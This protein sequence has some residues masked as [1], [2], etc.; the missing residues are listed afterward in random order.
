MSTKRLAQFT[1]GLRYADLSPQ[2]VTKTKQCI[3]DWLGV[4]I[5]GSQEKP[6]KIIREL[7]LNGGGKGEASVL[8]GQGARTT[9]LQAAFC[10]GAASH[11]LDFDDLHNPSIIHLATVVVPPVFA[12]AEAEHK[13][14]Q[15]LLTAVVAGYEVGARVGEAVIPESYFYW[16]TTGTAGTF[17]AGAS[18]ASIL[19][20]D[21][22]QTTQCLGSAGTQAA[23]LW[24]FLK[25]GAMSKTLHAGKSSYAGVLSACLARAG[26]TGATEILEGEKGFCRAMAPTPHLEKLTA[27]LDG[28][29]FKIDD[30]SFKPYACCKHSH[31]AL[32]ALA[33]LRQREHLQVADVAA[34]ELHVNAITNFLINNAAPE[35]P[36]GCKFSIQY[37]VAAMLKY[38]KMGVDEFQPAVIGDEQVRELMQKITVIEDPALEAVHTADPSK[39]ASLVV[40]HCVDGRLLSLQVDYPKGDPQNPMTWDESV[41]KFMSLATGVY[42]EAKAQKLCHLVAT[43]EECPDFATALA[44]CLE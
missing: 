16:H 40:V 35:N 29:H 14:G 25:E 15:E 19:G 27:G 26:F 21:A 18:A 38:G 22:D 32:Y 43:L 37:C 13:S 9:A 8:A 23:G 42:G 44:S 7:L 41:A 28:K 36:Y 17:G 33:V 11:A 30:N 1:A 20:L 12:L 4:C 5:R 2:T 39:L 10:N 6:I 3:L 24:E 31:A 34:I